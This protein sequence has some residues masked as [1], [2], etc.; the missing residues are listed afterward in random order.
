MHCNS[1]LLRS[2][3]WFSVTAALCVCGCRQR[4]EISEAGVYLNDALAAI[5]AGE[6]DRAIELLSKSIELEPE[7]YAYLQRAK[8][9][10]KL[11][12]TASANADIA[13]GLALEPDHPDLLWLQEQANKPNGSRFRGE[14]AE[15]PSYGK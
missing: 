14:D 8:L 15:P 5:D 10:L 2:A 9:Y 3:A 7:P 4:N 1:C 11:D 6:N 12:D 13:K